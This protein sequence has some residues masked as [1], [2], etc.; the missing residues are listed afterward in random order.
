[1]K[2]RVAVVVVVM[3][4][5]GCAD[6]PQ[7][8]APTSQPIPPELHGEVTTMM[9]QA[10]AI[11]EVAMPL[12]DG[13]YPEIVRGR[14][15][16]A[17]V[18]ANNVVV[19]ASSRIAP[20][21]LADSHRQ[22]GD[23]EMHLTEAVGYGPHV[24]PESCKGSMHVALPHECAKLAELQH[25]QDLLTRCE[26][27]REQARKAVQLDGN[28]DT[29]LIAERIGNCQGD[30]QTCLVDIPN[31]AKTAPVGAYAGAAL[32]LTRHVMSHHRD[33]SGRWFPLSN[34]VPNPQEITAT[35]PEVAGAERGAAKAMEEAQKVLDAR[36]EQQ[37]KMDAEAQSISDATTACSS[38]ESACKSRCDKEPMFC[39]A[40]A[41]RLRNARPPKLNDAKTYMQKGCTG[42]VLHA[43]AAI[44]G[45]DQQIQQA[46]AEVESLW[47]AVTEAGDDLTQKR[48]QVTMVS[49]MANN[50]RLMQ[51]V[52]TMQ[53]INQAI[54]V[55]KYCPTKKA[56]I[57]GASFAEFQARAT[58]HCR[59]EAPT[60]RGLSGADVTLT[61]DCQNVYA[62][63]CP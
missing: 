56:F 5:V 62:T 33:Q 40:W 53:T 4:V 55:E 19:L 21:W 15:N 34:G 26:A 44:A 48:H 29:R 12:R 57:T 23:A 18:E 59:D 31:M 51:S 25:G 49:Q 37:R 41:V 6:T 22:L 60:G 24:T 47:S 2:K 30:L 20:N 3:F 36:A 11:I 17:V 38:N 10:K 28:P 32:Y 61:A 43:C 9:A 14:A 39:L 35:E 42:G 63:A 58:K 46:A 52:R 1:M 50:P 45:I 13:A 27:A 16:A 8:Q 54:V 7:A